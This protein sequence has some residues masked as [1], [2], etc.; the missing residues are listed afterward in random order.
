MTYKNIGVSTKTFYGITFKPGDVKDVP[1]YINASGMV[2]M[3]SSNVDKKI[4]KKRGRKFANC[5]A[6]D[7][8]SAST[9]P[10]IN[11]LNISKE[12]QPDG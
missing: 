7:I 1:G 5:E 6:S 10:I 9:E 11:T 12:E 3:P 8:S 2:R 4:Y